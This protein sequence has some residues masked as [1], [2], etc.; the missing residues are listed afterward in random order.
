MDIKFWVQIIVPPVI[1]AVVAIPI[2]I[3]QYR[4]RKN[5]EKKVESLKNF[6]GKTFIVRIDS[7]IDVVEG[8]VFD[9]YRLATSLPTL[10]FI[11]KGGGKIILVGHRGRPK[12]QEEKFT[13]KSVGEWFMHQFGGELK[14]VTLGEF[15]GWRINEDITLLENIR[16]YTGEEEN[17]P[18]F[19]QSLAVL[20]EVFVN[21][22]FA[23]SHRSH[24]STVGIT[25]YLPSY[26]GFRFILEVATLSK[27]MNKPDRP[28]VVVIGGEKIE[29]KLPLV[30]KMLRFAEY[31]LVGG[32]IAD[33]TK[34]LLEVSHK[35]IEGV[36]AVLL[37]AETI[38]SVDITDKSVENFNQII[39][40]AKTIVWN[41]TMGK[42]DEPTHQET[43]K[44]LAEGIIESGAYSVVGG[45]DTVGFLD[46][47]CLLDSFACMPKNRCFLSTGG[48]AMLVFLSGE[49]LPGIE[50]L[51]K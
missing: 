41:G 50:A 24:A 49:K 15:S 3:W 5:E 32:K 47:I 36:K 28:L 21:E 44:K 31:I 23:T 12:G 14:D 9:D 27:V 39:R 18:E 29:T 1:S 4:K 8:K 13:L 40:W 10:E 42:V 6:S 51:L 17:N 35:R 25:K 43:T 45:G 16:F 22:A 30:E 26:A 34:T 46:K 20:G 48:G 37:L 7:D 2:T 11:R 38:D 33:E 19:A